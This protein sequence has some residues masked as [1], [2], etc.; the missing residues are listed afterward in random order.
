MNLLPNYFEFESQDAIPLKALVPGASD[1]A[2]DLLESMLQLN[3][4]NRCRIEDALQHP[5]FKRSG[6]PKN[7]LKILAELDPIE[8]CEKEKNK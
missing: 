1:E 5:F 7:Y 2:I 3:P 4:A 6:G 8:K